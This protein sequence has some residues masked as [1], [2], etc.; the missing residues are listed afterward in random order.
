MRRPITRILSLSSRA[1]AHTSL[2]AP[3]G[4]KSMHILA[5]Q[6]GANP[7]PPL[8][9][10]EGAN[11]RLLSSSKRGPRQRT[12]SLPRRKLHFMLQEGARKGTSHKRTVRKRVP[13]TFLTLENEYLPYTY[14]RNTGTSYSITVR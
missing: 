1:Q 14:R 2:P 8:Q 13:P 12:L 3:E 10:R 6:E 11:P 7:K 9:L 4:G 5:L